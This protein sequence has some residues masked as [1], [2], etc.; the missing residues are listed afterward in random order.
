MS[1][2]NLVTGH[3]HAMTMFPGYSDAPYHSPIFV[4]A[5]RS[6]GGRLTIDFLNLAY[7]AGVRD[8]N[9]SLKILKDMPDHLIGESEDRP[10][11][12]YVITMLTRSWMRAH[13]PK[14]PVNDLFD[15]DGRPIDEAF[16]RIAD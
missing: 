7:A 16:R 2:F 13:F 1:E 12:T 6:A 14:I 10:E 4:E 8:Q 9:L 11:R 15:G 3:W 5:I